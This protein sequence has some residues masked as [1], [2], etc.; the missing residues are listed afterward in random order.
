MIKSV[1]SGW[2]LHPDSVMLQSGLMLLHQILNH[3]SASLA[4]VTC[5]FPAPEEPLEKFK[6][7]SPS[8]M[9]CTPLPYDLSAF[10]AAGA[11]QF[12]CCEI[13]G[14]STNNCPEVSPR[15]KE[16]EQKIRGAGQQLSNNAKA[17]VQDDYAVPDLQAPVNVEQLNPHGTFWEWHVLA[18]KLPWRAN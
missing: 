12:S 4:F 17:L 2:T 6:A 15:Q 7:A 16:N 13:W 18:L 9:H 1:R 5:L 8:S 14:W 3:I 11:H 10:K